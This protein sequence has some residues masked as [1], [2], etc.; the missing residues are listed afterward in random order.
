MGLVT[1]T[2]IGFSLKNPWTFSFFPAIM[3]ASTQNGGHSMGLFN[4]RSASEE[5]K[6]EYRKE[7]YEVKDDF[8][9]LCESGVFHDAIGKVVNARA[10][11]GRMEVEVETE[12]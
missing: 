7:L 11:W 8:L 9:A 2:S 1:I 3:N 4:K 5:E 10:N 6:Q 12:Y